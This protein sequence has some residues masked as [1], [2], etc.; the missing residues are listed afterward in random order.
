MTSHGEAGAW[1]AFLQ[2]ATLPSLPALI[3]ILL[4]GTSTLV[5]LTCLLSERFFTSI[6]PGYFMLPG[7][8]VHGY[9][10]FTSLQIKHGK[11]QFP[12]VAF[13][14][15]SR[16]LHVLPD[17][18]ELERVLSESF[19]EPTVA[20]NLSVPLMG[21]PQLLAIIESIT[22]RVDTFV[23]GMTANQLAWSKRNWRQE[24]HAPA[25]GLSS[26]LLEQ[27]LAR[28]DG[29][30]A[31][32]TG[33]YVDRFYSIKHLKFLSRRL[34]PA[35]IHLVGG[36][37]TTT[38][39]HNDNVTRIKNDELYVLYERNRIK[40][41]NAELQA[42]KISAKENLDVLERLV[43]HIRAHS[44]ATIVLLEAPLNP[45]FAGELNQA[46]LRDYQSAIKAFASKHSVPY[47]NLNPRMD[48]EDRQFRDWGHITDDSVRIHYTKLLADELHKL[49]NRR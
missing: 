42:Y 44:N 1:R 25:L 14:G 8:D 47:L 49:R 23:I 5:I 34:L 7:R 43:E 33:R 27:E 45:R 13:I 6:A 35:A 24:L 22:S 3:G 4:V 10:T 31:P 30:K 32:A 15:A 18:D 46:V 16:M 37:A 11:P 17:K 2:A 9:V 39:L 12:S 36:P 29:V 40:R 20:Y 26:E 28:R 19:H 48:F 21:P 41:I 38:S